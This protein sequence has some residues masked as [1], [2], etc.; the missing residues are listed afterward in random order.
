MFGEKARP[1]VRQ[2]QITEKDKRLLNTIYFVTVQRFQLKTFKAL[3]I[4]KL[5]TQNFLIT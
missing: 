3:V 2:R 1:L 4:M 5:F